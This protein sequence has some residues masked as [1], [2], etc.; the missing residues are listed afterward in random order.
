M[1]YLVYDTETTGLNPGYIAQLSAIKVDGKRVTG[2]NAWFKVKEMEDGAAKANGLSVAICEELSNGLE[3]YDRLDDI[4][5]LFDGVTDIY[6]YNTKF[7][8]KFLEAEFLRCSLQ[9]PNVA[10]QDVMLT[11][12]QVM[13]VKKGFKLVNAIEFFNIE[14]L[15]IPFAMKVFGEVEEAHDARYDTA[16][17]MM[18]ARKLNML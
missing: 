15:V 7:D 8:K 11:A 2:F 10:W 16:A 3:F 13:Q 9:L 17:T 12:K 1:S 4:Q 5:E 18:L 14:D 6:G